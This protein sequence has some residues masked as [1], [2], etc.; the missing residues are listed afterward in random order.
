M[1]KME[2]F[3]ESIL[4]FWSFIVTLAGQTS[5]LFMYSSRFTP[6]KYENRCKAFSRSKRSVVAEFEARVVNESHH[7]DLFLVFRASQ[8]IYMSRRSEK[9]QNVF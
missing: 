3:H 7:F 6:F 1:V 8:R 5:G 9:L 4:L 2:L